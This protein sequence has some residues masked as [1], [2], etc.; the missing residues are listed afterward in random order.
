VS[1]HLDAD[2]WRTSVWKARD[3]MVPYA[4]TVAIGAYDV[5][6]RT[7]AVRRL[8]VIDAVGSM[9]AAAVEPRELDQVDKIV[10]FDEKLLGV[11]Y[12]FESLGAI[13][14]SQNLGYALETQTRPIYSRQYFFNLDDVNATEV[15]A[16]EQAHQWFGDLVSIK[17]WKD[18]WLNEGFATYLQW[19]WLDHLKIQT[20]DQ[21]F[22]ETAC[23]TRSETWAPPGIPNTADIF[24]ERVYSRGAMTLQSLRRQIGDEAFFS[25]LHDWVAA[26][27]NQPRT[28]QDFIDLA[29]TVSGQ[30]LDVF[31]QTWLYAP[32]RVAGVPCNPITAP[33]K[34]RALAVTQS[35]PGDAVRVS[36]QRPVDSG[37]SRV[38]YSSIYLD[39][40]QMAG[41]WARDTTVTLDAG[42]VA[43]GRHEIAVAA[44]NSIGTGPKLGTRVTIS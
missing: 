16:H 20:V 37:G 26:P 1:S 35:G 17:Q 25:L 28:T 22:N 36:W 18:V 14:S 3:P 7:S 44:Q 10:E 24:S 6:T 38:T 9:G 11:R 34:P 19:L 41:V 21:S 15:I 40:Q 27:S 33:A 2:G 32:G 39:G 13:V 30:Q 4:A 43:P 5:R 29:E 42:R 12:P 8:P 23:S 31:F